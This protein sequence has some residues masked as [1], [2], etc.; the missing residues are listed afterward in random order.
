MRG[1]DALIKGQLLKYL[2]LKKGNALLLSTIALIAA[3]FGVFFLM[4]VTTLSEKNKQR[5]AH[6]YNAYTMG[7]AIRSKIDGADLKITR[8]GEST[9]SDIESSISQ[10]FHDG[11][12]I[13]LEDMVNQS[14]IVAGDDPSAT[15]RQK[16]DVPYDLISSE[17]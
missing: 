10:L 4:S 14:I 11:N 16:G 8:L 9:K 17:L 5:I 6:L 1:R 2:I 7:H 15:S 13:T 3:T 12:F